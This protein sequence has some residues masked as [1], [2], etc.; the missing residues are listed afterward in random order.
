MLSMT[1]S[2]RLGDHN[3]RYYSACF[4]HRVYRHADSIS[5]RLWRGSSRGSAARLLH[6]AGR[7]RPTR[8]ACVDYHRWH[9][10]RAGLEENP[11]A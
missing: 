2:A 11:P 6:S 10:G 1:N 3:R 8:R 4:I 9:S 7:G 5:I